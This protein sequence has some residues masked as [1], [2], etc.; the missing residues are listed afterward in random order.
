MREREGGRE[1]EGK[2]GK[3]RDGVALKL[4]RTFQM[5]VLL[6]VMMSTVVRIG[7]LQVAVSV[8]TSLY[9]AFGLSTATSKLH[10][11]EFPAQS[12]LQN[13]MVVSL[14]ESQYYWILKHHHT[15]HV[16]RGLYTNAHLGH[17]ANN[18]L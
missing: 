14:V 3:E 13:K 16:Y 2:G 15:V 7:N 6:Y 8:F 17:P 11:S 10:L 18:W 9:R 4:S 1:G 5:G 12:H